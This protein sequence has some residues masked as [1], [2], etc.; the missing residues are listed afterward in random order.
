MSPF[1]ELIAHA[2]VRTPICPTLIHDPEM[3]VLVL[4]LGL[5]ACLYAIWLVV[6]HFG[7]G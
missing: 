6:R 2:A 5:Q 7:K 1:C 3:R 4:V